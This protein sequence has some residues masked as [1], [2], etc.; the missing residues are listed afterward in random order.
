MAVQNELERKYEDVRNEFI[1]KRKIKQYGVQKFTDE[2]IYGYLG[3]KYYYSPKTV[4]DIVFY[5][6]S[7]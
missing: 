1:K 4:Q 3:H 5:R 2:W 7:K 6:T